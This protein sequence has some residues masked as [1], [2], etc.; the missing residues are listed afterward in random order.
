MFN[1]LRIVVMLSFAFFLLCDISFLVSMTQGNASNS[2]QGVKGNATKPVLVVTPREIDFGAIG[3]S[4]GIKG[5]F[6][7]KNTG[8]GTV[9]WSVNGPEGWFLMETQKLSGSLR[10]KPDNLRIHIS[11]LKEILQENTGKVINSYPV[12]LTLESNNRF[13]SYQRRLM[14]GAHR[15]MLTLVSNGGTKTIFMR[16]KLVSAE[17]EPVIH[18]EPSRV[19]FGIA[20]SGEQ[21]SRRVKV[22]N[23][24]MN[25]LKWSAA[26]QQDMNTGVPLKAGR[27]ISFLNE[28]IIGTGVYIPPSQLK[29]LIDISGKWSEL[30][31]YP[32]SDTAN[33]IL[34]YRF[35]GTGISVF[36]SVEPDGGDLTAYVD[37]KAKNNQDCRAGQKE[38]AECIIAEGLAYGPHTL[39][40]LGRE[41][42]LMIEGVRIYGKD[43]MKGSPGWI[44]IFPDS[45]TTN[46]ETDFVNIMVNMQQLIPGYYGESIVFETNGGQ[47]VIEVSLEVSEENIQKI[48]DVYRYILG[49]DYLYTSNT[50]EDAKIIQNR[51]YRKQGI[52]FR[53]F[54]LNA[55]GTTAFYRWYHPG[56]KIHF[57]SYDRRGEGKALKGYIFQ[58]TI[59][60]IGT[61]RLTNT[62]ELYRWFNPVTGGHFYTTD[63]NGEGHLKKGYRFDG[64]AGYVR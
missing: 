53:L 30:N 29:D 16:F 51:G 9:E 6:V 19:D 35:W 56:K 39:T 11:S 15:E 55:P 43:L 12:Q 27:Y 48:M 37:E 49:S 26:V 13:V 4:E 17:S 7:I 22:T 3:P 28:D 41:G 47:A 34:K 59:G 46:R 63:P 60:N 5:T 50:Q 10:D 57:Y 42:R 40:V 20:R 2:A 45:G 44:S 8:S 33:H 32:S 21:V 23:R 61:S 38:R 64:I 54:S 52:A 18:V 14:P 36:F 24:G 31:G 25:T 58:G 62:R 1:R